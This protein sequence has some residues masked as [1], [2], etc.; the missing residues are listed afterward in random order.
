MR[1]GNFF[2]SW[3]ERNLKGLKNGEM[4]WKMGEELEGGEKIEQKFV[5]V[6]F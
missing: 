4:P 1:A 2:Q 6:T 5:L 3:D